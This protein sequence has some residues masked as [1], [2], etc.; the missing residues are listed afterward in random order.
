MLHHISF[1]VSDLQRS[2]AFYDAV[3]QTLDYVRVWSK[4]DAAGYGRPGGEDLFALKAQGQPLSV[5]GQG[6]HLAF[7]AR[8]RQAV[9]D[10]HAVAVQHGGLDNGQPGLR[11]QYGADYFAAFVIDPD[12]YAIEAVFNGPESAA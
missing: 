7:A 6:F 5:P 9:S 10:F 3:L 1:G 8:G 4:P 11:P 12:G 2:I